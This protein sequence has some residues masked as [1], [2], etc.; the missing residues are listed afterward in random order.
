MG[1]HLDWNIHTKNF[2][3]QLNRV[4]DIL[5]KIYNLLLTL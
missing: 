1:Q 3:P 2:I 4:L 5:S